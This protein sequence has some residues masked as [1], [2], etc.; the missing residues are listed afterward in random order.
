MQRRKMFYSVDGSLRIEYN[1]DCFSLTKKCNKEAEEIFYLEIVQRKKKSLREKYLT[2]RESNI[3]RTSK[4]PKKTRVEYFI[5]PSTYLRL[6]L[7]T[8]HLR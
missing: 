5:L 4:R 8:I 1:V 3:V 6:T 2:P 7:S